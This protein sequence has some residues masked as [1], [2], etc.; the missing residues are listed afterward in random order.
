MVVPD[1]IAAS[2]RAALV[3]IEAMH[4]HVSAGREGAALAAAT[5]A[6]DGAQ[7]AFFA[8]T[9]LAKL[10]FPDEHKYAIYTPFFGPI[11]IPLLSAVI[12]GIKGFIKK[13]REGQAAGGDGA[14]DAHAH[15]SGEESD[16]GSQTL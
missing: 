10:Y 14:A 11:S 2:V 15:A 12:R 8:P 4:V 9:I 13:R 16:D 3:D 1:E 6:Y 5:R 7:D